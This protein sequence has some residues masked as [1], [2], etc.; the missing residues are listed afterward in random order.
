MG[1]EERRDEREPAGDPAPRNTGVL[2]RPAD[3]CRVGRQA[4]A[5][6]LRAYLRRPLPCQPVVEVQVHSRAPFLCGRVRPGSTV[7]IAAEGPRRIAR[8]HDLLLVRIAY[9]A[10]SENP[11]CPK[12]AWPRPGGLGPQAGVIPAASTIGFLCTQP[13]KP[14]HLYIRDTWQRAGAARDPASELRD[15]TLST[16]SSEQKKG[17]SP[18]C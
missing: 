7:T 17:R 11:L 12:F 8:M 1:A 14:R 3:L 15:N 18:Y 6:H 5:R 2:A 9:P 10:T 4:V 16:H 13:E